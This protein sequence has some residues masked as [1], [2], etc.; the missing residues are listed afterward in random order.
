MV[1][2]M[3]EGA[4]VPALAL[5]SP[6]RPMVLSSPVGKGTLPLFSHPFSF[7]PSIQSILASYT[8]MWLEAK[9]DDIARVHDHQQRTR[10]QMTTT[11]F[12]ISK[13]DKWWWPRSSWTIWLENHCKSLV[14]KWTRI[15]F[16]P[17]HIYKCAKT[18]LKHVIIIFFL[19]IL[20]LIIWN[21]P[22][23]V[24]GF[25]NQCILNLK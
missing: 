13:W 2:P 9:S 23:V 19:L 8:M 22:S 14:L 6:P 4:K 3:C 7:Q 16:E 15:W 11:I 1:Q 12:F 10:R 18:C 25:E 21:N 17:W 24:S 20:D 5:I